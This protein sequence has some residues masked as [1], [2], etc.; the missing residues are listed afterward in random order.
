MESGGSRPF[1]V[2][3]ASTVA[4]AT[5]MVSTSLMAQRPAGQ[6]F[7]APVPPAKMAELWVEPGAPRDLLH[8]PGGARL[9]PDPN[10]TY[11]VI[12]IKLG[13]FSDGYTVKD[14]K[15]REWSAKFPPEAHT[16]VV[17]SRILWGV[18]FHQPPI[19][20]VREWDAENPNAP[21]PQLPA[22]FR[23]KD[24]DLHGLK[25][26]GPWSF[27]DNPFVGA[28]ELAGLLVLQAM[29]G[30]S[31]L[32]S[33]NNTLYTLEEPVDG[34]RRWF[35]TRD[36][37]HTFG[38]TGAIVAPRGDIAVFEK[39]PFI[40]YV[41]GNHVELEYG[42]RHKKLFTNITVADVRWI[43]QRLNRLTDQQW[44]DAFRAGGYEPTIAARFIARL[45]EKIEEGLALP[46]AGG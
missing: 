45:K 34:V 26:E 40:R 23:E 18:G 6:A 28:R 2:L 3:V 11:K 22:R 41:D 25:D 39:T 20:F 33:S 14:S 13:G 38:R 4:T 42:G 16:E 30:N 46:A 21:N 9:A 44:Q 32:K 5:L 15:D 31:D 1:A 43:C 8:G 7:S 36:V 29:L 10:E 37:G 27:A 17:A 35:T 19:Y 24:P 12:E